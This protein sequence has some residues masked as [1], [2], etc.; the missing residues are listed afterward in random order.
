MMVPDYNWAD[1]I[2]KLL[3]QIL[4]DHEDKILPL[5]KEM[6]EALKRAAYCVKKRN[7]G[8]D[9]TNISIMGS[10]VTLAAGELLEDQELL[11]YGENRLEKSVRYIIVS[12]GFNEYNSPH[13]ITVVL[14]AIGSML[15]YFISEKGKKAAN[16]LND[17]AWRSLAI[18]YHAHTKQLAGPHSRSYTEF[19]TDN[20][21]SV[22]DAGTGARFNIAKKR[23]LSNEALDLAQIP[24]IC[25]EKYINHFDSSQQPTFLSDVYYRPN[26]LISNDEVR[27]LMRNTNTPELRADTYIAEKF[28]IGCFS[29][30]DLWAQRRSLLAYWGTEENAKYLRLRCF[31]DDYDYSSAILYASQKENIIAGMVGFATDHGDFHFILDPLNDATIN[32]SRLVIRFEIGGSTEKV[33]ITKI[34]DVQFVVVDDDDIKI[35]IAFGYCTFDSKSVVF[36]CGTEDGK[37]Y[38]DVVL[39]KGEEKNIDFK[40]IS[41]AVISFSL[42]INCDVDIIPECCIKEDKL[43]VKVAD[44]CR[45]SAPLFP[46]KYIDCL[47]NSEVL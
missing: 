7:V 9:Y 43:M 21:L 15:K 14:A 31:H 28:C 4:Y 36:D 41:E 5:K 13:Y 10:F 37:I 42:G 6:R 30:M 34:S 12:G 46:C 1:F 47:N 44:K 3:V 35:N 27:T 39:Y 18:H 40:T 17:I 11:I 19:A 32:A 25:P 22:I 20:L 33:T 2:G 8:A 45:L 38:L 26:D 23:Q 24:I 29:K 16:E